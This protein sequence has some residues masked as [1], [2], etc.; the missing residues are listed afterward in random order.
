MIN[1]FF[2]YFLFIISGYVIGLLPIEHIAGRLFHYDK[3]NIKNSDY[4]WKNITIFSLS[5]LKGFL[6]VFLPFLFGTPLQVQAL[7]GIATIIGHSWSPFFNPKEEKSFPLLLGTL[8]PLYFPIVLIMCLVYLIF[9]MLWSSSIAVMLSV[10]LGVMMSFANINLW[11]AFSLLFCA[12]IVLILKRLVPLNDIFP[13]SGKRD[14]IENRIFFDRDDVPLFKVKIKKWINAN[15][16]KNYDVEI[17]N[18]YNKDVSLLIKDSKIKPKKRPASKIL[19]KKL[20]KPAV[21]K[22]KK[23][24]QKEKKSK[25]NRTLV[26]KSLKSSSKKGL[27]SKKL[28]K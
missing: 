19:K 1:D 8:L 7:C 14:L 26:K 15:K 3:N 13:L 28:E 22:T 11:S 24:L 23:V 6:A 12:L 5:L 10:L 2:I 16:E 4:N 21:L 17:D 27:N 25:I 9:S 18:D 20:A